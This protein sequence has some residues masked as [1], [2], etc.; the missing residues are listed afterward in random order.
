MESA[1]GRGA[2]PT[3]TGVPRPGNRF[4]C[5]G[6]VPHVV[7]ILR[8]GRPDH[9]PFLPGGAGGG[10]LSR[11]TAAG[12]E[13]HASACSRPSHLSSERRRLDLR[14]RSARGGFTRSCES[15]GESGTLY[16][17]KTRGDG[18]D[19][20]PRR[21]FLAGRVWSYPPRKPEGRIFEPPGG[22]GTSAPGSLDQT[23]PWRTPAVRN[24]RLVEGAR[25]RFTR[26]PIGPLRSGVT[27]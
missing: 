20:F 8:P 23:P 21:G 14:N 17:A 5:D 6:H 15:Q 3:L 24:G 26:C 18:T 7:P 1:N 2:L 27:T 10:T 11:R 4:D 13:R 12:R 9:V 25:L 19:R 16:S 22:S